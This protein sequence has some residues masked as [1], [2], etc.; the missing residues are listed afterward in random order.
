MTTVHYPLLP[1]TEK[2]LPHILQ[3]LQV[4][5]VNT[6]TTG[7]LQTA[8]QHLYA[9][10]SLTVGYM[11]CPPSALGAI[12]ELCIEANVVVIVAG[13]PYFYSTN[14][15][16]SASL[17]TPTLT[18]ESN[19]LY[20]QLLGHPLLDLF[21]IIGYQLYLS[22]PKSLDQLNQRYFETLRLGALRDNLNVAEPLLRESQQV[23]IDMNAVRSSDAPECI[24]QQPNGMYAEEICQLARYAGITNCSYLINVSGY[25]GNLTAS[26]PTMQLVAQVI[27]HLLSGIAGRRKEEILF[28]E[29][30]PDLKKIIVNMDDQQQLSFLNSQTS[31]RWWM[32]IPL[33][34]DSNRWVSCLYDDYQCACR[35]EVP[36]RWIWFYQKFQLK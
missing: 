24:R 8:L 30:N 10:Q 27:W 21:S 14:E 28:Y 31:H 11:H 7:A 33:K 25:A 20:Q 13:D 3:K 15:A 17:I 19:N 32:K 26:S 36:A 2:D 29:Q 4:L 9:H 34:N 1:V 35:Q 18:T 5:I 22:D 6:E 12:I 23:Y 16:F